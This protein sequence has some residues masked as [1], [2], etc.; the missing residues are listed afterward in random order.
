MV[1]YV[2]NALKTWQHSRAEILADCGMPP[3]LKII[4]LSE[5]GERGLFT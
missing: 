1:S 3:Y 4:I 5:Y 2:E